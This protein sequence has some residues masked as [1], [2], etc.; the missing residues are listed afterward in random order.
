MRNYVRLPIYCV[1]YNHSVI[2]RLPQVFI[3]G[4]DCTYQQ[5]SWE[6]PETTSQWRNQVQ[7]GY[8]CNRPMKMCEVLQ[9]GWGEA[10]SYI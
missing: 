8:L 4:K 5:T 6:S 2:C 7:Q 3:L 10:N 9:G 1:G